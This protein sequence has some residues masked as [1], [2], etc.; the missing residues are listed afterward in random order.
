MP[1]CE[2]EAYKIVT[3]FTQ[4]QQPHVQPKFSTKKHPA[5]GYLIASINDSATHLQ[6][7]KI[8]IDLALL[9]AQV[10]IVQPFEY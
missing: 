8:H 2:L 3:N 4:S 5:E 10:T 7:N 1:L 9:T 6:S